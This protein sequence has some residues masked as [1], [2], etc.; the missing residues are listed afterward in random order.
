MNEEVYLTMRI[1][2]NVEGDMSR[3]KAI[4]ELASLR[5]DYLSKHLWI[6]S[7]KTSQPLPLTPTSMHLA[8]R[9]VPVSVVC[10]LSISSV[11]RR[12]T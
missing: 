7:S 11:L 1:I 10:W 8:K 4:A 3:G 12:A 6:N 2:I 9:I 5:L